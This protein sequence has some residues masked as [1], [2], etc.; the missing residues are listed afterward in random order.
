MPKRKSFVSILICLGLWLLAGPAAAA[1]TWTVASCSG[2]TFGNSCS[3]TPSSGSGTSTA[4]AWSTTAN[5]ASGGTNNA[6]A[7]AYVGSYSGGLG[8]TNRDGTTSNGG[9]GG[10]TN[11]GSPTN[12]IA[13]EHAVDNNGR[14]D[15]VL[16]S[17]SNAVQL[18]QVQIGYPAAGTTSCNG[19]SP[20]DSDIT[21]LAYT[22][23]G[24]GNY[25]PVYP[26]GNL[27]GDVFSALTSNGWSFIGNYADVANATNQ[28][29]NVN[30]GAIK[31][32]FWL[33][34]AYDPAFSSS[35]K[36]ATTGAASG[37]CSNSNDYVKILSL[38]GTT[39][40]QAPEPNTVLLLGLA[41]T[42]GVW[43]KRRIARR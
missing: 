6:M 16:F 29:A 43:G 37:N 9:D 3:L 18:S 13:P 22:G 31:S 25:I 41:A 21:V 2:S 20:C 11:E 34:A 19:V 24:T 40:K 35:C 36:N 14:Y 5:A 10:D 15:S 27:T 8:V 32:Q 39:P 26:T 42:V 38:S 4:T 17:F 30:A 12:T 23:G 7:T 33:V 1:I 28:T